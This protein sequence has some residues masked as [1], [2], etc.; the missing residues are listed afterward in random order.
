M[1]VPIYKGR[2]LWLIYGRK[3]GKTEKALN[4]LLSRQYMPEDPARPDYREFILPK[5]RLTEAARN[6]ARSVLRWT[7]IM[8]LGAFLLICGIQLACGAIGSPLQ[9]LFILIFCVLITI[10]GLLVQLCLY[11]GQFLVQQN[12]LDDRLVQVF[13]AHSAA[14]E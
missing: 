1:T 8:A 13:Q 4:E 2:V 6:R 10:P 11:L 9:V 12:F 5:A 14:K 3:E 7:G